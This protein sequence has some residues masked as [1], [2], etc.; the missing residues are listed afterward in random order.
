MPAIDRR[1]GSRGFLGSHARDIV[2]RETIRLEVG[3]APV[4]VAEARSDGR[5]LLVRRDRILLPSDALQGMSERH[6]QIG[7][8]WRGV[9]QLAI[10]CDCFLVPSETDARGCIE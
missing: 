3:E 7:G 1:S 4:G 8:V 6:M 5:G 10:R 2:L 9:E